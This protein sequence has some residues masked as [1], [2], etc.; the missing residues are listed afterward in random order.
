MSRASNHIGRALSCAVGWSSLLLSCGLV[1]AA[2]QA[3]SPAAPAP[4]ARP[5]PE[6]RWLLVVETSGAMQRRAEAVQQIVGSFFDSGLDGQMRRNDSVGLW[7]F[8]EQLYTGRFGLQRWTPENGKAL[9]ARV[10]EFLKNQPCEKASH[11]N[12]VMSDLQQVI[13]DSEFI[14]IILITAGRE[15]MRGTPFDDKINVIY[16]TWKKAQDKAG[17]PFVTVL[18]AQRGQL[19]SYSVTVP[20]WPLELPPLPAELQP[21]K[22]AETKAATTTTAQPLPPVQSPPTGQAL[23]VRGKKAET[24]PVAQLSEPAVSNAPLPAAAVSNATA[25]LVP[26]PAPEP[27]PPVAPEEKTKAATPERPATNE[28]NTAESSV[29]ATPQPIPAAAAVLTESNAPAAP[30]AVAPARP[31]AP[32]IPVRPSAATPPE[33][34]SNRSHQWILALGIAALVLAGVA[35]IIVVALV[36]RMRAPLRISLIDRSQ[37]REKKK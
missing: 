35:L 16:K 4:K 30:Q 18:R 29:P 2:G 11:L 23:I 13:K 32:P 10:S 28:V 19:K 3:Q 24:T 6:N 17:L 1:G 15:Q 25:P 22:P 20:P 7:T 26:A 8:N 5:S 33:Q 27:P 31:A 34:S 21:P 14:T 12:F 9:G 37:D 36:R